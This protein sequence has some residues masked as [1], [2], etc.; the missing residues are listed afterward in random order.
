[1]SRRAALAVVAGVAALS[2]GFA[3]GFASHRSKVFPHAWIAALH[4]RYVE[5]SR[6]PPPSVPGRWR[7]RD[8]RRPWLVDDERAFTGQ[9]LQAL[10]YAEGVAPPSGDQGVVRATDRAWPGLS[11]VTSGHGPEA[12]LIDLTGR[13]V[14]SWVAPAQAVFPEAVA[15]GR[16]PRPYLRRALLLPDGGLLAIFDDVGAFRLDAGSR[17]VWRWEGPAHHHLAIEGDGVWVLS[18]RLIDR[19]ELDRRRPTVD[20]ELVLLDLETGAVR[21]SFSLGTALLDS[22]LA[23][24]LADLRPMRDGDYFHTNAVVV[25]DGAHVDRLPEFRAGR[26]L[27]SMRTPAL[28]AVIDPETE[29]AAWAWRGPWRA[30]HEPS[31]VAPG[32][33]LLFDNLGAWPRSRALEVDP[34]SHRIVWAYDGGNE[35]VIS[36]TCGVVQRLPGDRT[37]IVASDLGRVLEVDRD[38]GIL[39]EWRSPFRAGRDGELVAAVFQAE[40]IW[41]D[42]LGPFVGRVVDASGRAV[43]DVA[44]AE[45]PASAAPPERQPAAGVASPPERQPAAGAAAAPPSARPGDRRSPIGD[46]R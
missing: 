1:V 4:A 2:L 46:P 14:A 32:H 34:L 7:L 39:W 24:L 13:A 25:L 12:T 22:P 18:R 41:G 36:E 17:L 40:R 6:P 20:D 29:R 19:P 16:G 8:G 45:V 3:W 42:A 11:L 35:P 31:V 43:S 30:Q 23:P 5:V 38:G 21:R 26:L 15:A 44:P 27:V 33:L 37:V 10:G 9:A 28:L